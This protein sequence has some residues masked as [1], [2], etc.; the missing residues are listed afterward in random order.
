MTKIK[1]DYELFLEKKLEEIDTTDDI[2]DD[3]LDDKMSKI[4]DKQLDDSEDR[5]TKVLEKVSKIK[6]TGDK[7]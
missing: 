5:I 2:G 7:K 6:K 3:E 4:Y 1:T